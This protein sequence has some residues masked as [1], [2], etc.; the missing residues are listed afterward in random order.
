LNTLLQ[1]IRYAMRALRRAPTFTLVAVLTLGLGI[2]AN[3]AIFS[4]VSGVLLRPLPYPAPER[5]VGLQQTFRG[6]SDQLSL[7]YREYLFLREHT[8]VLQHLAVSTGAGFTLYDGGSAERV[9]ALHVSR[10]YFRVLGIGPALGREFTADE[11]QSGGPAVAIV[12]DALWRRR[13]A[14]DASVLG[15]VVSLDGAPYT[16][17]GVMPSGFGSVDLW[18]TVAQVGA[19]IGGGQNLEMVGR[20]RPDLS[21]ATARAAFVATVAGLRN[22]FSRRFTADNGVELVSWRDLVVADVRAP[23]NILFGAIACVLLIACAN[24]AGLL[25]GRSAGRSRELAVRVAL[26][27]TATRL[28]RQL[29]T[30]SVLLGLG[31]GM[32]AL[33][34]AAWGLNALIALIPR[35]LPATGSI[36]LDAA[37]LLFTLALSL[38]TGL[39]FGLAPSWRATRAA[40]HE[41]L[42]GARATGS[43]RQGRLRDALVV[44]E[45]AMSLVLLVGAILLIRTLGNLLGTDPGFQPARVVAAELWLSGPRYHSTSA[46][47][48][49]YDDLAR[50]VEALPGVTAAAVVDAGVPLQRG[51]N[52]YAFIEGVSDGQSL[53]YRAVTNGYFD[54]LGVTIA[55]GRALQPVDGAGAERVAVVNA[56]FARRFLP[57]GALG[58]TVRLGGPNGT[59]HRI[60]GVA[61]DVKSFVGASVPSTVFVPVAQASAST[62][63]LFSRW[64]PTHVIARTAGDP[65]ALQAELARV[66]RAADPQVAAG[67][68]RS[69]SEVLGTSLSLQRFQ[70]VLLTIFAGLALVLAGVGV[71]GLMAYLVTQRTREMGLRAALGARPAQIERLVVGRAARLA[72]IGIALGVP[73]ALALTRLLRTA[74]YGIG[75]TNATAYAAAAALLALVALAAAWLPARRAATVDPLT[76]LRTE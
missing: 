31:G 74:L 76:A 15:R 50:R 28:A 11:D 7:S 25:V 46:I 47:A 32:V 21:L 52:V 40:P 27:A 75:A 65:A 23:L 26:G 60:V 43:G 16:V 34:L 57:A 8:P 38:V 4:V 63:R 61:R 51:G 30:E 44:A 68:V 24:V 20:M 18:T 12:S 72:L 35:D 66:I 58:R 54:A 39:A 36:G 59:P 55:E 49:F 5:L 37:A 29:L 19:T 13:F 33:V 48:R 69:M 3:T 14:G 2:G 70:A 62:S 73:G 6:G 56:A 64:F 10:D 22:E 9:N 17:I 53:D 71:Y 41:A 67:R 45:V 1:D 42:Q